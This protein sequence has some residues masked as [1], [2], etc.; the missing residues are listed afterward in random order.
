MLITNVNLI[1]WDVGCTISPQRIEGQ[2][3]S[4]VVQAMG[5]VIYENFIMRDGYVLTPHLSTTW[6]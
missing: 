6:L 5:Y 4:G 2:I 1:S 3:E